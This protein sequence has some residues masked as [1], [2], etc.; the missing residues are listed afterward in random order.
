[1]P[2]DQP[3]P[4]ARV[5][6]VVRTK[7]RPR[8]LRRALADIDAQTFTDH[9]V[10]VVNDAGDPAQV[11]AV[12]AAAPEGVRSRTTVVHRAASTGMEAASNAGLRASA[13]EF[14]VIHDDDDLWE[15]A[16]LERTVAFLDAHPATEA[17]AVRIIIRYEREADGAFV[18]TGRAPFW[19]HLQA[20]TIEDLL[21]VNRV[22]PIGLL[23][24][25]RLHDEVGFYNE[26][27]PVV[28][29]WEFNVRVASRHEIELLDEPLAYW[30]QRPEATGAAANSIFD[31]Q[32]RHLQHDLR[33]RA[34]AIR[35]D[36]DRGAHLGP[37]FF[38][39]H[40]AHELSRQ[41]DHRFD[42]VA[43]QV[44]HRFD[45]VADQIEAL[46]RRVDALDERLADQVEAL[47]GRF[48]AL[49]ERLAAVD[50]QLERLARM[51]AQ[52]SNPLYLARR[53]FQKIVLRNAPDE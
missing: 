37:Y 9:V 22:V 11:D 47:N 33:V 5:A 6:I 4:T 3:L 48:D 7:D 50:S 35:D 8:F 2:E 32:G 51:V 42:R 44:D 34:A 52:R 27:L 13:S 29:D 16:F 1:M 30:C 19:G 31:L 45:R 18:E 15:P 36:L 25:R 12:V 46:N 41:L 23:Y 40:L 17:V 10:V 26:A 14:C 28:G 43:D 49:D 21:V 39:A 53:G 38:Q 20:I 24:R